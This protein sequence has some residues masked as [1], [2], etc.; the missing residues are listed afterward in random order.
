MKFDLLIKSKFDFWVI[1]VLFIFIILLSFVFQWLN[2]QGENVGL[3][4]ASNN[5][6]GYT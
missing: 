1:V 4:N 6:S 5:F 3:L 2:K